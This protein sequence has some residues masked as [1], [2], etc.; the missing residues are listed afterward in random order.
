MSPQV[1]QLDIQGTPQRWITPEEAALHYA[2]DSVVWS[3][4]ESPLVILR[5]GY[6]VQAKRQSI[7]D[8]APIIAVRGQAAISSP[9]RSARR[10]PTHS[11]RGRR[12]P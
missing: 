11:C 10:R 8:I 7:L 5:G 9:A 1:L 12:P 6:N 2:A 3:I 4:G